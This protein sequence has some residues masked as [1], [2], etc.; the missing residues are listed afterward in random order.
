M[1]MIVFFRPTMNSESVLSTTLSTTEYQNMENIH[2]TVNTLLSK[3]NSLNVSNSD[4]LLDT[5]SL[6]FRS[7]NTNNMLVFIILLLL[8]N[9]TLMCFYY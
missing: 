4:V 6:N 2:K 7:S 9:I 8:Y 1:I 3:V 5:D